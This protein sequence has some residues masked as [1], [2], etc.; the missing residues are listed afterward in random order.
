MRGYLLVCL[1]ACA[2]T[3]LLA[4]ACRSLALR[5]GAVARVR[6]RDVHT[7]SVP[8]FGG[9]AMLGG[10][11]A[12]FFLASQMPFLS[13]LSA[14]PREA[15]AI[16]GGAAVICTVGVLDD[17]FELGALV[18]AAG[19]VLAAGVTVLGGVRLLWIPWPGTIIALDRTASIIVTVFAVFL[20][21]TAINLIDGLDGLAAG[22]VAIGAGA[23]FLYSY[24]LAVQE[25]LSRA[26]T[27]S[28]VAVAI[29]GVCLGY[30]P[31]N[32]HPARMFMGDSG[33]M[34]LGLLLAA[35]TISL[36]GQLN[37]YAIV[38]G[39]SLMAGL[40]PIILPL[41]ILALP[42][43]DLTLAFIRRT[44]RG[45]WWFKAD[46]QH[47]HHRLLKR[48]H[49]HLGAVMLMYAWTTVVSF[50]ILA[51]GVWPER[52]TVAI[53]AAVLV[54]VLAVTLWPRR[55]QPEALTP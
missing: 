51:L 55:R 47:L 48:G 53:V 1:T 27:A 34:L 5:T 16:L 13:A 23:F 41:A 45:E 37:P 52:R 29:C 15:L 31:H 38:R 26:T 3:L 44:W 32:F 24:W 17:L 54:L 40:M 2:V 28:L 14:V 8:Y 43:L 30:L 12:A 25:N 11:A 9:L 49:S 22:V 46:K 39:D 18:K 10:V 33:S 21:T 50:G 35:S 36:T 4:P 19:Q 20:I 7:H 6:D 42:F